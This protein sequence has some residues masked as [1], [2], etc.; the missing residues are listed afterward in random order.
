MDARDYKAFSDGLTALSHAMRT[1][2]TELQIEAYWAALCDVAGPP[3]LAAIA[4][5]MRTFEQF[6]RPVELLR[7]SRDIAQRE[8][9]RQDGAR[10]SRKLLPARRYT[11]LLAELADPEVPEWKKT[12]IREEW[13]AM[14]AAEPP[15]WEGNA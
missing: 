15:P 3:L 6:P 4:N 9:E 5:G 2:I 12:K 7:A 14:N 1:E 11:F 10:A 8:Q 13:R